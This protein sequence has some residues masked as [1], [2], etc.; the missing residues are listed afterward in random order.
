M[1]VTHLMTTPEPPRQR[2]HERRGLLAAGAVL[3]LGGIGIGLAVGN[4]G[5]PDP[6]PVPGAS[7]Q[8]VGQLPR[9]TVAVGKGGSWDVLGMEVGYPRTA[10]GAVAAAT[11]YAA[12]LYGPLLYNQTTRPVIIR[13]MFAPQLVND[14]LKAADGITALWAESV[15][16]DANGNVIDP[17]TQQP[18]P[19]LFLRAEYRPEEGAYTLESF[20]ADEARVTIWAPYR[21]GPGSDTDTSQVAVFWS[22]TSYTVRWIDGDWKVTD[23]KEIP[24]SDNGPH[25]AE[26]RSFLPVSLAERARLVPGY[27][28]YANTT[29]R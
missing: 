18:R 11:N 3:L 7:S 22:T 5:A 19:D 26:K 10:D 17:K 29:G 23:F 16:V 15:G 2:W 27:T 20:S 12:A 28:L 25:P 24:E 8:V 9:G 4:L 13:A 1:T 6:K 14:M 21:L